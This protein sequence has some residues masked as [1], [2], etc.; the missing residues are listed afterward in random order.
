MMKRAVAAAVCA[1]GLS[2]FGGAVVRVGYDELGAGFAFEGVPPP[3]NNDAATAAAFSLADGA[4]DRNGGVL[5]VLHDGRVPGGDDRP[6]ENFFFQAGSPG[7]RIVV[8]LGRVVSVRQ[9]NTYSWHAGARGPQVYALYAADGLSKLVAPAG[10]A[11]PAAGGWKPVA[12]VDTRPASGDGGGQHGVSVAAE[13][14]GVLGA[15]RYLLFVVAPTETRDPFGQTFFSEIDVVDAG[16]PAPASDA[17]LA[18]KPVRIAFGSADGQTAYVIDATV[19]PDLAEWAEKE[20]KPVVLAWYPKLV[21][22]LQSDGYQAP[23]RVIL[24]FKDDLGGTPAA[25][26]GAGVGLN[27]QWFRKELRR[28]ACGAVVHELAHVVQGYG[29]ARRTNPAPAPTP[30]WVVEGIADY[31]RWFLYEPQSRGA[32]ITKGN[33]ERAQYDGSYRVSANFLDWASRTYDRDLVRK[34]NA[35]AREGRYAEALWQEWTGKDVQALGDE[36]LA[37]HKKRLAEAR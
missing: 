10:G 3:A 15:Y 18:V 29:H 8:D 6:G 33:L 11:E 31:A 2:A 5:G 26:G 25:A 7:G 21:A 12:R 30:G 23:K 1:S 4:G 20:L 14:G 34:L 27:A 19:A 28:E 17:A 32:E 22:L 16:G 13:G 37:A 36:W 35:A 9:V 24:R